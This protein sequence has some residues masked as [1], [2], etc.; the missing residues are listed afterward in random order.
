MFLVLYHALYFL[1]PALPGDS[2]LASLLSLM[3]PIAIHKEF[4]AVFNRKRYNNCTGNGET[5][6]AK[7][8]ATVDEDTRQRK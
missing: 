5:V 1:L 3:L 8:T 2:A 6:M 4:I 7:Y